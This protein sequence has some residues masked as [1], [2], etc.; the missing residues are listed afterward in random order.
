MLVFLDRNTMLLRVDELN[1]DSAA[2][3]PA[4]V[5]NASLQAEI[6]AENETEAQPGSA[7]NLAYVA[8]S[9]G[10]YQQVWP[11]TLA[12]DRSRRYFAHIFGDGAGLHI[13]VLARLVVK[14]RED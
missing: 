5:N 14:D 12:F 1:D 8:S 3:Q 13:D 7:I 11:Y 9:N 10:R 2:V 6:R 4:Y